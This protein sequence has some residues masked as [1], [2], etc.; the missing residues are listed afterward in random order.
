MFDLL[1]DECL[2]I[3]IQYLLDDKT[4]SEQGNSNGNQT[5]L[6]NWKRVCKHKHNMIP[7]NVDIFRYKQIINWEKAP[8]TR[9]IPMIKILP[10]IFDTNTIWTYILEQEL[11]KGQRYKRKPKN[12]K[13]IFKIRVQEIIQKR[14]NPLISHE[15]ELL[16]FFHK[17]CIKNHKQ[18]NILQNALHTVKPQI[19]N[20]SNIDE[21]KEG[22]YLPPIVPIKVKL[23]EGYIGRY[24][25][26]IP[27]ECIYSL[28]NIVHEII[29][30]E[31]NGN[32]SWKFY[33]TTKKN[34]SDFKKIVNKVM[35]IQD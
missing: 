4:Q 16:K 20:M 5:I 21:L 6:K 3:I 22:E 18:L 31:R 30:H 26:P 34:I 33:N 29:Y 2:F 28:N 19:P 9:V 35:E 15:E 1:P 14:Y 23:Q 27:H 17:E 8:F 25:H 10:E 11:R 13:E 24:N 7:L 12:S 32:K